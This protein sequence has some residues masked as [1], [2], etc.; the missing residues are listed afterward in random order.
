VI[1]GLDDI[2][3]PAASALPTID[4]AVAAA[5]SSARERWQLHRVLRETQLRHV[6]GAARKNDARR[7]RMARLAVS[8]HG[9]PGRVPHL[10]VAV[11]LILR[12]R[13][14]LDLEFLAGPEVT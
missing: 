14:A 12:A 4:S 13:E 8:F 10:P 7:H 1:D 9:S 11:D 5:V 3:A 2:D 6:A